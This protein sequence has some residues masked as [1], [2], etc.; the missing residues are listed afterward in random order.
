M[1]NRESAGYIYIPDNKD[2]QALRSS[3]LKQHE[4]NTDGP[5]SSEGLNTWKHSPLNNKLQPQQLLQ[6]LM[7]ARA[8]PPS[9]DTKIKDPFMYV[10]E[11]R[12]SL[13]VEALCLPVN[14]V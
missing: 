2:K 11:A 12:S 3:T 7:M 9:L 6:L 4:T 1:V 13:Q 8:T 14:T 5:N 10:H